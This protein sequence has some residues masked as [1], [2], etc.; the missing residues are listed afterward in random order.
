PRH[1]SYGFHMRGS[2]RSADPGPR[3]SG[4]SAIEPDRTSDGLHMAVSRHRHDYLV[5]SKLVLM[6]QSALRF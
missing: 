1:S 6:C 3:D 4:K 5:S 2:N